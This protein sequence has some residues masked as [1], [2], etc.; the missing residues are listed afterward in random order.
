[1]AF[2]TLKV[3]FPRLTPAKIAAGCFNGPQ[4]DKLFKS[5]AFFNLLKENEKKAFEGIR[6]VMEKFL[7]NRKSDDYEEIVKKMIEAFKEMK[8]RMSLK[9]HFLDAHL[10]FFPENCGDCSDEQGE[11]FHQ[12]IMEMEKRFKGK[13]IQNMLVEYCWSICRNKSPEEHKRK[14]NRPIFLKT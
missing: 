1:M 6:D 11:R 5:D 14:T 7:G 10:D 13:D 2:Q 8:V 4:I 9:V 12:D 3:I